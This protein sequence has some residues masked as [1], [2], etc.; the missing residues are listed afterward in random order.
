MPSL[1]ELQLA[2][3]EA[4]LSGHGNAVESR[5]R[6]RNATPAARLAIYRGNTITNLRGALREVYPIVNKLVGAPF[7]DHAAAEFIATHPSRSGDLNEYGGGFAEFLASYEPAVA[8][9]YLPGVARM[10]WALEKAYY[11]A[12]AGPL[13]LARLASVPA[14]R[15][16]DLRLV[17]HPAASL[18]Q[19]AY[20]LQAIWAMHQPEYAGDGGVDL[21]AG[22]DR[23][24]ITRRGSQTLMESLPQAEFVFLSRL[25][26]RQPLTQAVTAALELDAE[27]PLQAR[28]AHRVALGDIVD[29]TLDPL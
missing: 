13:E 21:A 29:F 8:L 22:G 12:D 14:E 26:D 20:P 16:G 5:L 10:E 19:S 9:P 28:L 17:L 3:V 25:T 1:R 2:F 6:V 4:V 27:F 24:L 15:Y 23:L 7:F 11:A 18:V